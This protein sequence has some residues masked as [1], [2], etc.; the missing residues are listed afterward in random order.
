MSEL[1]VLGK[2]IELPEI[3]SGGIA[4]LVR[5]AYQN[6]QMF[7][8]VDRFAVPMATLCG[9]DRETGAVAALLMFTEG[10]TPAEF[11]SKYHM[12]Q[13]KPAIRAHWL[14]GE[15]VRRGGSY[16][17]IERSP[18]RTAIKLIAKG[19]EKTFEG[20]WDYYRD[21]SRWPWKNWED[22]K[23][24]LKSNWS[25]EEDR[26]NMLWCRTI[27]AA[28]KTMAP[29][30]LMGRPIAEELQDSEVIEGTVVKKPPVVDAMELAKQAALSAKKA[31]E[32]EGEV[33]DAEFE[34]V[35]EPTEP[36]DPISDDSKP[37]DDLCSLEQRNK[38]KAMFDQLDL[39]EAAVQ[40]ALAKRGVGSML[41]LTREQCD[42]MIAK[43]KDALAKN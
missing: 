24:G 15:F 17:V 21:L 12:I 18:E 7:K 19:E 2:E 26:K 5:A 9:C 27:S 1:A 37:D 8:F 13:G 10:L 23:R 39:D 3:S 11:I 32:P 41:A 29:E 28:V 35:D 40:K 4:A 6:D 14:L 25:T 34:I 38:L 33:V 20:T 42:E 16:E 22:K 43:C 36:D 30:V 31:T